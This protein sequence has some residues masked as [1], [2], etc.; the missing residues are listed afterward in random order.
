MEQ[1]AN[2]TELKEKQELELKKPLD[3]RSIKS[4]KIGNTSISYISGDIIISNANRIFGYNNW[5]F[6]IVE[7]NIITNTSHSVKKEI[8]ENNRRTGRFEEK[9][10]YI[11]FVEVV[12]RL[13]INGNI[14]EDIGTGEG[15]AYSPI[16]HLEMAIK[17]AVTD[18]K[19]RCFRNYG[20][21]FGNVLYGDDKS[22]IANYD[23]QQQ[24]HEKQEDL[25]ELERKAD[26]LQDKT[27][28]KI[29][30]LLKKLDLEFKDIIDP[31]INAKYVANIVTEIDDLTNKEGLILINF[32]SKKLMIKKEETKNADK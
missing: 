17:G 1:V 11:C 25:K 13:S 12:G 15:V 32:L 30:D 6:E 10:Q 19:K 8:W 3:A 7:R 23:P 9:Q 28:K 4:R 21:Q 20:D 31:M 27:S 26:E 29:R 16:G 2:K 24:E 5:K 22:N 14:I 18:A